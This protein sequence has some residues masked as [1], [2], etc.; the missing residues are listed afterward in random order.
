MDKNIIDKKIGII[1]LGFLGGS[2]DRY[3]TEK[4]IAVLR[5]DKKGIGSEEEVNQADIIFICVNTPFDEKKKNVDLSYAESA[6]GIL[7]E[8]KTI[9]LRS[10][11][12]PGATDAFQKNFPQHAFL[13]NPEFLRAATA[14]ED[15]IK[16]VRQL[17]G[18]TPKSAA[19][20]EYV[21]ALLPKASTESTSILPARAAELV[22][23]VANT[24]LATKVALANKAFDFAKALDVD[25][26]EIKKL[27]GADP[28]IGSYGLEVAYEGFRGYNGTC[29][30]KDVRTL[31]ALGEKLG[32]DITWL[33]TMDDE[34]LALLRSQKLDPNYGHPKAL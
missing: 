20:A 33:K 11:V 14:Y 28:R 26:E 23:Y 2:M 9:V 7:R 4:G 8:G 25:Y 18:T 12:P 17:V 30:P 1:G 27:I 34:N 24:M 29:F 6:I 15:F 31:I 16:P 22:K 32:V 3:F 5:Y 21:M 13:C 19:M 10:T